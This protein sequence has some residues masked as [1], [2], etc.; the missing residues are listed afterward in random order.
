MTKNAKARR[1]LGM[2]HWQ[3]NTQKVVLLGL[4]L[5]PAKVPYGKWHVT[6]TNT[7]CVCYGDF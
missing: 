7:C 5:K 2:A 4:T 1:L 6:R 3:S